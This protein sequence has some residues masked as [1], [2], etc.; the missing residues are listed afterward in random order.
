MIGVKRLAVAAGI[1]LVG[2]AAI[3][4]AMFVGSGGPDG[5]PEGNGELPGLILQPALLQLG[6]RVEASQ[7]RGEHFLDGVKPLAV[8]VEIGRGHG[9]SIALRGPVPAPA[10]DHAL[11]QA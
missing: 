11:P 5:E 4:G 9:D 3:L 1:V 7:F 10:L 2:T 6:V 8:A